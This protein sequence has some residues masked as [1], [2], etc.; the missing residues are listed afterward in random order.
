MILIATPHIAYGEL[1]RI[2]LEESGKYQVILTQ[3]AHNALEICK[4]AEV[5]QAG[6]AL[7]V[8]D[9]ELRD[10][11]FPDLCRDLTALHPGLR[12]AV[13]PPENNP[14]HPALGPVIPHAYL[15][16]ETEPV[17]LLRVVARLL[18]DAPAGSANEVVRRRPAA[19][20]ASSNSAWGNS[21]TIPLWLKDTA[22]LHS[23]L[24]ERLT[25]TTALAALVV[26]GLGRT[27]DSAAWS[28]RASAGMLEQDRLMEL[29]HALLNQWRPDDTAAD[30]MRFFQVPE[31]G[32]DYLAFIAPLPGDL[33]L[34][35]VYE[36]GAPISQVRSQGLR[37]AQILF[38]LPPSGFHSDPHPSDAQNSGQAP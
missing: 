13:L 17:Q 30:W 22:S 36:S 12:L 35:L 29:L 37:M 9:A 24:R 33:S 11:P 1:L 21:P 32:Q 19:W 10:A 5:R 27:G 18:E 38:S 2:S 25:E 4:R 6:V 14:N 16:R 7:A 3:T 26:T 20:Y 8:L 34:L 23:A 28:L 31:T 15:N